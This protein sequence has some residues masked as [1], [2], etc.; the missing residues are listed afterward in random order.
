MSSSRLGTV[1]R[2]V[3][4]LLLPLAVS[5][6]ACS[7]GGNTPSET[8]PCSATEPCPSGLT[9]DVARG[10]CGSP[11]NFDLGAPLDMNMSID[12]MRP[13]D[14]G[15]ISN[16]PRG[17]CPADHWCWE[18]PLP[19]GLKQLAING[20]AANDFWIVG[21]L[22]LA[23]HYDGT[24]YTQVATGTHSTLRA[25]WVRS[26]R[27]V[28]MVG[29]N[30]VILFWN[31]S[32]FT[33]QT[34]GTTRT[35]RALWGDAKTVYAVG[36]NGT[37]LR[38]DG[39]AW[40]SLPTGISTH[41]TAI[42]G[43]GE[44]DVWAGGDWSMFCHYDGTAWSCARDPSGVTT[45][46]NSMFG[47]SRSDIWALGSTYWHY[48]GAAWKNLGSGGVDAEAA[49]AVGTKWWLV[50]SHAQLRHYDGKAWKDP[51]DLDTGYFGLWGSSE[52]NMYMIGRDGA[53]SHYDGS[54]VT[55]LSTDP[56]GRIDV[57]WGT[58]DRDLWMFSDN[59]RAHHFD[60]T[61]WTLTMLPA[62]AFSAAGT[63]SSNIWV[64]S[65]N[66]RV[67]RYDGTTWNVI[68]TQETTSNIHGIFIAAP[69]RVV[70]TS[71][72]YIQFWDGTQFN[73]STSVTGRHA[74]AV[75]G[76]SRD[77]IWVAHDDCTVSRY[78]GTRWGSLKLGGC[79]YIDAISGTGPSDVYFTAGGSSLV[80]H[81]DGAKVTETMLP[82]IGGAGRGIYATPSRVFVI[83]DAGEVLVLEGGTW[84]NQLTLNPNFTAIM[85][86]TANKVW[87]GTSQGYA[88]S[89]RP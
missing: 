37:L 38:Y 5:L 52:T 12:D 63:S 49:F 23:M 60:G 42:W 41:L 10:V 76:S 27:E 26:T 43:S 16:T 64:G 9:C 62:F 79:V 36:E 85:G 88:L 81:W 71:D 15:V 66:G 89:Y 58:S 73:I 59:D 56:L 55:K 6:H 80:Y 57:L 47:S 19:Q 45:I 25:I 8:I 78:D 11:G 34:S 30:G 18:R 87:I 70:L 61:K 74:R 86:W 22:G 67:M 54:K 17:T 4:C 20:A 7:K 3:I 28:W 39:S 32:N 21:E 48:D 40:N 1:L 33:A 35:L 75:W 50:N 24:R 31:G 14:L 84:K 83:T 69:D 53:L 13:A 46:I 51:I 82:S 44:S 72:N 2:S 65:S 68:K 77:D 29:D